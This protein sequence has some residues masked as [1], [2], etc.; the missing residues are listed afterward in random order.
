MK[1]R[2]IIA[3]LIAGIA[4]IGCDN[5]G[6]VIKTY[7][8]A[9]SIDQFEERL[10]QFAN[11]HTDMNFSFK[12]RGNDFYGTRDIIIETKSRSDKVRYNLVARKS[13]EITKIDLTAIYDETNSTEGN[14][15]T[16]PEASKLFDGFN[17]GF[18]AQ[19]KK[20]QQIILTPDLF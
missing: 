4:F 17:N 1:R 16:N 10:R 12:L 19:L 7:E 2:V 15:L 6:H 20:E 9:G 5:P 11:N 13:K 8:Y 14:A 18:R 3:L